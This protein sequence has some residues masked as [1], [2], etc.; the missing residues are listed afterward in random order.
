MKKAEYNNYISFNFIVDG[1]R[2][3]MKQASPE[4]KI[5]FWVLKRVQFYLSNARIKHS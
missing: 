2:K 3:F 1:I 5:E 4:F